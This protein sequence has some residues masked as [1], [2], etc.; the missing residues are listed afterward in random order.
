MCVHMFQT[1]INVKKFTKKSLLIC[2]RAKP[3]QAPHPSPFFGG[4]VYGVNFDQNS[5]FTVMC[6]TKSIY[7]FLT[8]SFGSI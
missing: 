8:I 5:G 3:R 1:L 2:W 6:L 4:G 7:G